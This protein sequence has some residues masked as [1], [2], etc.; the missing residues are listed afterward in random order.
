MPGQKSLEEQQ[1]YAHPRNSFWPILYE[2]FNTAMKSNYEERKQLLYDHNIAVWDVLNQCYRKGS[3]DSD[4]V[5][6]SIKPNDFNAFF[7]KHPKIKHI[8]FNGSKAEQ[9]F[10]KEILKNLETDKVLTFKKLP[11]TSPAHAAMNK[12][13]KLSEWKAIKIN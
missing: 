4:I 12:D 2:L 10:K 6:S 13:K 11:S 8:F 5:T 9:L 7:K 1:Y 3:L